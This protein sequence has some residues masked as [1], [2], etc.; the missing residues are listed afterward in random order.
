MRI[1][2]RRGFTL[3]ELIIVLII[4]GILATVAAPMMSGMKMKAI[5][6][7]A[8]TGLGTIRTAL[9]QYYMEYGRYPDINSTPGGLFL[10]GQS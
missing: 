7:E 2:N 8:V 1:F 3:I 6:T 10:A 9:R 4:I 5:C